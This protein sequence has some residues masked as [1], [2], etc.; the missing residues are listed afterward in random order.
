M[1]LKYTRDDGSSTAGLA[2][3]SFREGAGE[4]LTLGFIMP[5]LLFRYLRFKIATSGS[6]TGFGAII[7][8]RLLLLGVSL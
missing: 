5:L 8:K 7:L 1:F 4:K 6:K 2:L 3:T